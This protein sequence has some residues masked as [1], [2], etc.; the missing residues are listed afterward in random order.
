LFSVL[1]V[2]SQTILDV[3]IYAGGVRACACTA[4]KQNPQ[5]NLK[6]ALINFMFAIKNKTNNITGTVPKTKQTTLL[7]LCQKLIEKS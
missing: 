7:E 4:K 1:G 3:Y 6:W 5:S 2:V